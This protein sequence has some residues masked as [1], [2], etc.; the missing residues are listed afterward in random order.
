[1]TK[2]KLH[3]VAL[4][5]RVRLSQCTVA[6]RGL[7]VSF[8]AVTCATS[9]NGERHGIKGYRTASTCNAGL[10]KVFWFSIITI[11]ALGVTMALDFQVVESGATAHLK[12]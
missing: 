6:T 3:I 7:Q 2:A 11:T 12:W 1:M 8:M 4:Y 9:H 5:C 10:A